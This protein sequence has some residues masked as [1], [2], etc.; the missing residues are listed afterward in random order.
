MTPTSR[1]VVAAVQ[2]KGSVRVTVSELYD[3]ITESVV[4]ETVLPQNISSCLMD[5][6]ADIPELDAFTF[7]NRLRDLGIGSADFL[8]LLKSCDC[9]AEVVEKIESNPAMSLQGLIVTLEHAGLEPKDYTRMLYS[10]RK[11]WERTQTMRISDV[12]QQLAEQQITESEQEPPAE[13]PEEP[14]DFQNEADAPPEKSNEL[15]ISEHLKGIT[16][17]CGEE[18]TE[19]HKAEPEEPSEIPEIPEDKPS[20][21]SV[22]GLVAS[23]CG[24]AVL[25]GLSAVMSAGLVPPVSERAAGLHFA[26]SPQ[27]VFSEIYYAYNS[28][29]ACG[30]NVVSLAAN[31]SRVFCDMLIENTGSDRGVYKI[32]GNV[33]S[34]Y[35]DRVL[36]YDSEN[37]T[38]T[39]EITP[40]EGCKFVRIFGRERL[41]AVYTGEKSG[42]T[43]LTGGDYT[44]ELCGTLTDMTISDSAVTLAGVYFPQFSENF[45]A[46]DTQVYLPFIVIDGQTQSVPAER[47]VLGGDKRAC[48]YAVSVTISL[49]DGA[50]SD[51]G[52]V[53]GD[54][55]YCDSD[56]GIAVLRTEEGSQIIGFDNEII[57]EKTGVITACDFADG[58]L[59]TVEEGEAVTAYIRGGDLKAE[60]AMQNFAEQVTAVEVDKKYLYF[61]GESGVFTAA[62]LKSEPQIL[63]L[64][65]K[66]GI[67]TGEYA[68]VGDI[69][70]SEV[71]FVMYNSDGSEAAR[72]SKIIVAD[73]LTDFK[74][75]GTNTFVVDSA[76]KC[77]AAYSYFDGVSFV[78]EFA[79]FGSARKNASLFDD[80]TGF[81]AAFSEEGVLKLIYSGGASVLS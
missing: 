7:L 80:S 73:S 42:I 63:N 57:S 45:T 44:A 12:M 72:C 77:G 39:A 76:V 43:A 79:Q 59:C 50:V 8:Y 46:G 56:S 67:I 58:T 53:L 18:M 52:A 40:P 1:S 48:G 38:Q 13:M 66:Y 37:Y 34:A 5:E 47:I 81:T 74:L 16:V 30:E 41:Y 10:A 62:E 68:L 26:E 29:A 27:E 31:E 11:I 75:G 24:A 69:N 6:N 4:P 20:G 36:V 23:A 54:A 55:Q 25:L 21:V 33:Y 61:S 32:G 65:R 9:P 17:L 28:G 60:C 70:G 22:K 19:V 49:A 51:C 35:S 3:Y 78:S 64:T 71:S 2:R 14:A 15:S